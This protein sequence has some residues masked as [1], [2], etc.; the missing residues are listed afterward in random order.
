MTPHPTAVPKSQI[1]KWISTTLPAAFLVALWFV[2]CGGSKPGKDVVATV[3]GRN[4]M[5]TELDKYYEN[6]TSGA[7]QAPTGEQAASLRLS[8]LKDLVDEEIMLQRAEKLGLMATDE[9]VESKLNELKAPYT[10]EE[11]DKRLKA[12]N[13]T[14]DD[15]KRELR[16]NLTVD[17][18]L[19]KEIN[20]KISITDA[21]ISAYYNQHKSEFNL[22]EPQYH[23]AR[24][25]V[26]TQPNPQIHNLKNDKAQ[27]ETQAKQKIQE[28]LNRLQSGEDFATLAMNFSEDPDTASNGG[29][30]G[31]V[32]ESAFR[33]MD[34]QVRD[35][36]TKLKPGQISGVVPL[37]VA[38]GSKQVVA[39]AIIRLLSKE[40][41]GQRDLND[42]RVQQNIREQL[43]QT[44][45]QLLKAAY[46]EV[47]RDEAKVRN[48]LAD[49]IVKDAGNSK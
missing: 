13:L 10:Q 37:A 30:M 40:P 6:Q 8:I 43:R 9:E 49:D 5:R 23:L 20:S 28:L 42:P 27:N 24:I 22:V 46:Y 14:A 41:A 1:V 19:N 39:F 15:L 21:D 12:K 7:P 47:I 17:K 38:P 35:V 11:F 4:I 26:T 45:E 25:V 2:G 18:V 36:V 29:D 48:Y 3:N 33:S 32:P 16:R 34:P 31:F 44:K